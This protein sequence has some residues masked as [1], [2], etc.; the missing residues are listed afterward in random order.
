MAL[1]SIRHLKKSYPNATPLK[2]INCEIDKGD[3]ISIIGPSGTGK[4]TLLRC[5]NRLETPTSGEIWVDG[6]NVCDPKTDLCKVRQ[7]MGMVFQGFNLFSHK[8]ILENI[9]MGP[10]SLLKI[11]RAEAEKEAMRLL[12]MVGLESKAENFPDELS[13][14]QKQRAAIART[15]A[16]RPEIILFDEPTSAL[17][18]TMVSEVLAVISSLAK[19]GMTM[20]IVTHEMRFARDV[21]SRILFVDDGVIYDDNKPSVIFENPQKEKTKKFIYRIRS[22]NYEVKAFGFDFYEMIGSLENFAMRQFLNANQIFKLKLAFEELTLHKLLDSCKAHGK[23]DACVK[24]AL[25]CGEG[26]NNAELVVDY[27]SLGVNPFAESFD[28]EISDKILFGLLRNARFMESEKRA[29]F[30]INF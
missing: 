28:D 2:D 8:T 14:G 12:A 21:S 18:P 19:Q 1:I 24:L 5:I 13:G 17:D 20:M 27:G 3:V 30:D 26:G 11:P 6:V 7:K 10:V 4:S 29:V 16:M 25:S 23:T 22:W 15:L 9:T